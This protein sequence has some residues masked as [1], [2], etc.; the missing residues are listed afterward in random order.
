MRNLLTKIYNSINYYFLMVSFILSSN[1][2][3]L[4]EFTAYKA[5]KNSV[6]SKFLDRQGD[7]ISSTHYSGDFIEDMSYLCAYCKFMKIDAIEYYESKQKEFSLDFLLKSDLSDYV[8]LDLEI[9]LSEDVEFFHKKGYVTTFSRSIKSLKK[10]PLSYYWN[11]ISITIN[12][13][14]L[15]EKDFRLIREFQNSGIKITM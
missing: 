3:K 13:S 14:G 9:E 5:F 8:V 1:K 6:M 4:L 2:E 11:I 15:S 12:R 7:I 10:I